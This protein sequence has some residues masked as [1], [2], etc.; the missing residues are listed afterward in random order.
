[1]VFNVYDQDVG[2]T[3][4]F[5]GVCTL[6]SY[7]FFPNG[8]EGELALDQAGE[9]ILAYLKIKIDSFGTVPPGADF[10]RG[11]TDL[12][13]GDGRF[14]ATPDFGFSGVPRSNSGVPLSMSS[15]FGA[16]GL[17]G[18]LSVRII[19][20]F[21]LVNMDSGILGDVSDPYVKFW[22]D[23]QSEEQ[24]QKTETINNDLNPVWS[25]DPY[26]F[27]ITSQDDLLHLEVWDSDMLTADDLLGR[28][29]IPIEHIVCGEPNQVLRLRDHLQDTQHGELEV[30]VAFS[31]NLG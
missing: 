22:L 14:Q 29:I 13:E 26:S 19:A 4:D 9:N 24:S 31:P 3:D 6:E 21:N 15:D 2:K 25:T 1:V 27:P 18:M 5:L 10:T 20:A 8:F 7:Q 16:G 11:G 23:S 28:L 17:L 30:E 12:S